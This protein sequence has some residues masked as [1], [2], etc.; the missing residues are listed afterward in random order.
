MTAR[1]TL[2]GLKNELSSCFDAD[3]S[4][5]PCWVGMLTVASAVGGAGVATWNGFGLSEIFL[6]AAA[7]AVAGAVVS[8]F[9]WSAAAVTGYYLLSRNTE[10]C[11]M[12]VSMGCM[13]LGG[14]SQLATVPAGAYI[15]SQYALQVAGLS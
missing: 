10:A 12:T 9:T 14:I 8:A 15:A 5:V 4:V 2:T 1:Q 3:H 11:P 6:T 13:G 7:S